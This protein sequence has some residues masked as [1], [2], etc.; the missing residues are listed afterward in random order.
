MT[1]HSRELGLEV[2]R[3]PRAIVPMR[4]GI[5]FG[6][7]VRQPHKASVDPTEDPDEL[8]LC[9]RCGRLLARFRHPTGDAS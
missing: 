7:F 1:H 6:C 9:Q 2:E 4:D 8:E 3:F 5:C